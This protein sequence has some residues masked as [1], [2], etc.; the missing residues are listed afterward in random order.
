MTDITPDVA[1]EIEATADYITVELDGTLLRV[2]PVGHWR[3]SYLRALRTADF[4]T[5]AA[6]AL[7]PEDVDVFME[8]DATMDEIADFT[9]RAM[10]A[11]GEAPGKSPTPSRS[12]RTTRRR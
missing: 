1:Q 5:W 4:D 9:T 3:P 6:L 8:I 2:R 7:H 10:S 12:S 11:A